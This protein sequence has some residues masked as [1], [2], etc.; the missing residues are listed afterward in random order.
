MDKEIKI[1]V[2]NLGAYNNGEL[3]G[4]WFTL[5]TPLK[6]IFKVVFKADELDEYG[7]PHGDYAIHDYEA[8]FKIHEYSSIERLNEVAEMFDSLSD[9]DVELI[10]ELKN[11]GV[12]DNLLDGQHEL[13]KVI[14]YDGCENMSDVAQLHLENQYNNEQHPLVFRHF[15]Y[16]SYGEEIESSGTFFYLNNSIVEYTG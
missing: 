8:S 11:Q 4:A 12:I 1:Y 14:R 16:Q 9:E 3:R 2:A 7:N 15:N 5:P 10:I 13:D 6:E